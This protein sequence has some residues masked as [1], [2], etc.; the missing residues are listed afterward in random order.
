MEP[1]DIVNNISKTDFQ[2][3]YFN[4]RKPVIISNGINDWFA[5]KNWSLDYFAKTYPTKKVQVGISQTKVFSYSKVHEKTKGL[6]K[7]NFIE[8]KDLVDNLLNE[9]STEKYYLVHQSVPDTFQELLGDFDIPSWAERDKTYSIHLWVGAKNNTVPLHWDSSHN[10]LVQLY[11][12]KTLWLFSADQ[13]NLLYP[14]YKEAPH[15]HSGV[16]N[17]E[18]PDYDQYPEFKKAQ[19]RQVTLEPGNVLFIPSGCWH[20]VRSLSNSVSLNFWWSPKLHE[21]ELTQVL[22]FR[23]SEAF[24][25]N[26]FAEVKTWL[27]LEQFKDHIDTAQYLLNKGLKWPALVF[28]GE[29]AREK[30]NFFSK[31]QKK[32]LS[33]EIGDFEKY[34]SHLTDLATQEDDSLLKDINI[35]E[36]ILRLKNYSLEKACV[37]S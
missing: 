35:N 6:M 19:C 3:L 31:D 5:T 4:K 11:G 8:M 23:V 37:T 30:F 27:N 26:N 10:F 20:Q 21:C 24:K 12:T 22:R 1:V 18:N 25:N 15:N 32:S 33:T 29:Y 16:P 14:T 13:S 17:I 36:V 28:L 9:N 34:L 7:V 2:N